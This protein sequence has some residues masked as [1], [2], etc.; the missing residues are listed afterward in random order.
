MYVLYIVS[1]WCFPS[2]SLRLCV[3]AWWLTSPCAAPPPPLPPA[4]PV[5]LD[6]SGLSRVQHD[7]SRWYTH[8]GGRGCVHSLCNYGPLLQVSR[9]TQKLLAL[10]QVSEQTSQ[11]SDPRSQHL[12][13]LISLLRCDV[14]RS[15]LLLLLTMYLSHFAFTLD[16]HCVALSFLPQKK[17]IQWPTTLHIFFQNSDLQW[18]ASI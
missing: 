18:T 10:S 4:D 6:I 17:T 8:V 7:I 5:L 11:G 1:H 3:D 9:S 14:M 15:V 16:V 12:L 2:F 13:S